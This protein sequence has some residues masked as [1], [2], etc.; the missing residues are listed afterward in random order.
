MPM[1]ILF[2]VLMLIWFIFGLYWN[3]P[4]DRGG[5]GIVGGH[6]MLFL[7]FMLLGWKVFGPPLQ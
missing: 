7:L 6:I 1:G 5:A 2:W 4:A 3:W